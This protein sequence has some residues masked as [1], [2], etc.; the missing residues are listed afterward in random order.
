MTTIYNTY[1]EH[2]SYATAKIAFEK[3]W[4]EQTMKDCK[5]NQSKAAKRL[6]MSRGCLRAKL[7]LYFGNRYFRD[8]E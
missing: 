2:G 4:I 3:G 7:A 6:E 5:Y 1:G 8:T